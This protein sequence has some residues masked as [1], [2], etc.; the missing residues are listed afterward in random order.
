MPFSANNVKLM[1]Q[2]KIYSKMYKGFK[3]EKK[4][5]TF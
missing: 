5:E 3:Q 4:S 2:F 1:L